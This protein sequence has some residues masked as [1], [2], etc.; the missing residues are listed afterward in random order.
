[1]IAI[2]VDGGYAGRGLGSEQD[3][4]LAEGARPNAVACHDATIPLEVDEAV[5]GFATNQ[6]DAFLEKV[7]GNTHWQ[8][9]IGTVVAERNDTLG[10]R[11]IARFVFLAI[12][13]IGVQTQFG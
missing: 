12:V 2:F 13:Q 7:L 1:M 5:I 11:A 4:D 3:G 9:P 10:E 6:R 8:D